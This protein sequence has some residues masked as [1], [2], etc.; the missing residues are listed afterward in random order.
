[1]VIHSWMAD[2][3]YARLAAR[4]QLPVLAWNSRNPLTRGKN[5]RKPMEEFLMANKKCIELLRRSM[6]VD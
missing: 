1:M 6:D 2:I 4:H 5:S 3:I